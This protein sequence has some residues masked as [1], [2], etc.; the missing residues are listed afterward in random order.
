MKNPKPTHKE[1]R[2]CGEWFELPRSSRFV[3]GHA[4]HGWTPCRT[5]VRI[6]TSNSSTGLHV[7]MR[8]AQSRPVIIFVALLAIAAGIK[9]HAETYPKPIATIPIK[10][11][12]PVPLLHMILPPGKYDHDYEGDLTIKMVDSVEEL[13][14][15]CKQDNPQMLACSM[16]NSKACLIIMVNDDV[17]RIRGWTTG[18]LL[19]HEIGHCNGWAGDHPGERPLITSTHWVPES[20]RV[21]LSPQEMV[22]KG[23]RR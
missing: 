1:C 11:V 6:V 8:T 14:A 3:V 2:Q 16:H 18:L 5:F 15:L 22:I 10:N 17:M 20:E 9:A 13:R 12:A 21:R 19:R 7:L 23:D 4:R